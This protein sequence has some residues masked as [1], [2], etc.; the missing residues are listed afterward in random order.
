M[1]AILI[2]TFIGI[3]LMVFFGGLLF[4]DER[5]SWGI[6][7]FTAF[8]GLMLIGLPLAYLLLKVYK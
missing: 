1:T 7:I 4:N 3:V 5:K 6:T 8:L 2:S